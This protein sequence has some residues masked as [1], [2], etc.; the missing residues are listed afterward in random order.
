MTKW[1]QVKH[2][3]LIEYVSYVETLVLDHT[4]LQQQV[5]DANALASIIEATWM[6]RIEKLTDLI[7][8]I[9]PSDHRYERG[10]LDAYNV[11]RHDES[12]A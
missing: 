8:D 12:S 7:M 3:D 5:R 11:M 4:H 2:E 6:A 10:M 1:V 9:H